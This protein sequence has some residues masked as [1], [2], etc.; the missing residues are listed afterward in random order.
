MAETYLGLNGLN[1]LITKIKDKFDGFD[2]LGNLTQQDIDDLKKLLQDAKAFALSADVGNVSSLKTTAETV[3]A[4]IN[5]LYDK[6]ASYATTTTTD[7][8]SKDVEDLKKSLEDVKKEVGDELQE[9]L[10]GIQEDVTELQGDVEEL[11]G[12]VGDLTTAV[13]TKAS[14]ADLEALKKDAIKAISASVDSDGKTINFGI[15][16]NA[17]GGDGA[18]SL[19]VDLSD[20]FD[21]YQTTDRFLEDVK[22][23]EDNIV[24]T[25]NV[26][27][28]G[29]TNSTSQSITL[30][31]SDV[32]KGLKGDNTG[33]VQVT[34]ANNTVKAVL[35][36]GIKG[37]LAEIDTINNSIATINNNIEEIEG[38]L[39][40]LEDDI[41]NK[42]DSEDLASTLNDYLKKADID[43]NLT[44]YWKKTD[45]T[46]IDAAAVKNAWDGVFNAQSVEQN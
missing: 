18:T 37:K 15:V 40:D 3:V 28:P 36:E 8:I 16:Y 14:S 7:G 41:D 1:A 29:S 38:R 30:G 24:F 12:G 6:F 13:G 4:A 17:A 33:D 27:K 5:E 44:G 10:S 11:Q 9:T 19:P 21:K 31:V 39:D 20:I 22:V 25:F 26:T 46:E 45:L 43:T 32:L 23:V 34:V 42:V 2:Q 35:S